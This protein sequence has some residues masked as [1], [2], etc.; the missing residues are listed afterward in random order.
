MGSMTDLYHDKGKL[1]R[2]IYIYI[3]TYVL[4]NH[5]IYDQGLF[6]M[7]ISS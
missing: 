7:V 2:Y 1:Y 4:I 6:S 5:G 3:F